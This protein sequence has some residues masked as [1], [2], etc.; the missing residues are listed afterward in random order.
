MSVRK[1]IRVGI[2]IGCSYTSP[3]LYAKTLI[4]N[5]PPDEFEV[6]L[7]ALDKPA[8]AIPPHVHLIELYREPAKGLDHG[9]AKLPESFPSGHSV[10][11]RQ[12]DI[13][14][15]LWQHVAPGS[16]KA[17]AGHITGGRRLASRIRGLPIDLLHANQF[18]GDPVAMAA[19]LAGYRVVTTLHIA[20]AADKFEKTPILV[21]HFVNLLTVLSSHRLI[22]VSHAIARDWSRFTL[23]SK[24]RFSVIHHGLEVGA[25]IASTSLAATPVIRF[26][27]AAMLHPKKGQRYLI[28]AFSKLAGKYPN[29]ELHIAGAGAHEKVLQELARGLPHSDRV[30]FLGYVSNMDAFYGR[31]HAF[32]L[33]SLTE[34]FGYVLIESMARAL[35]V[36]ASKV[37]AIPEIVLDGVTGLLVPAADPAAL[38]AAMERLV[39]SGELRQQMGSRG[40]RRVSE[41]FTVDAMIAGTAETYRSALR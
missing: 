38:C 35:P 40:R 10:S 17:I 32:V 33:P 18:G 21:S 20:T 28:E 24:R 19:R 30:T 41:H 9:D 23:G 14:R 6:T 39:T 34:P 36:I 13:L 37:E 7:I 1:K 22:A 2:L 12:P 26:G 4:D 31:L 27:T 3:K 15:R 25:M 8:F 29:V 5:L 11:S 16:L